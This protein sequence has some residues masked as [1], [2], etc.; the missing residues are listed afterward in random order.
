ML[1]KELFE[2]CPRFAK[3]SVNNCPL[4][5]KY[6]NE[7]LSLEDKEK[8]CSMPKS[9]RARIGGNSQLKYK[10]LTVREFTGLDS[11]NSKTS[12]EQVKIKA[13]LKKFGFTPIAQNNVIEV[14]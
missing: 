2:D 4:S 13:E 8:K 1:Q 5:S 9:R 11:W 7:F 14:I 12:E 10:G 3:C 6:P